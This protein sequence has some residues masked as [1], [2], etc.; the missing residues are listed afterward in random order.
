MNKKNGKVDCGRVTFLF[1]TNKMWM[2]QLGFC[3]LKS[4]MPM[5]MG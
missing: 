5:P 2:L 3:S 4:E 1:V